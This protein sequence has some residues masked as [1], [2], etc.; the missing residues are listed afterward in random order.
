MLVLMTLPMEMIRNIFDQLVPDMIV[1]GTKLPLSD[2]HRIRQGAL[3]NLTLV[4]HFIGGIATEFLYRNLVIESTEQMVCLFRTL[5]DKPELRRHTWF[6]AN[7]V[8]LM[9]STIQEKIE[10]DIER[11]FPTFPAT[12][13]G[14]SYIYPQELFHLDAKL[15]LSCNPLWTHEI[16]RYILAMLPRLKDTLITIRG[17]RHFLPNTVGPG[18]TDKGFFAEPPNI[19]LPSGRPR[20]LRIQWDSN[21]LASRDQSIWGLTLFQLYF[22]PYISD[23]CRVTDL[24]FLNQ[25][26][27][28]SYEIQET[29]YYCLDQGPGRD[30]LAIKSEKNKGLLR[31]LAQLETLSLGSSDLHPVKVSQLLGACSSLKKLTWD[32]CLSLPPDSSGVASAL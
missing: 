1:T 25:A 19:P 27:V 23:G 21:T 13:A 5:C 2:E 4:S 17:G 11:H 32:P 12:V 15:L 28:T 22:N 9:D 29:S 10:A 16:I 24:R 8:T 31:W 30:C 20:T 26:N 3:R 14:P 18:I 6:V 7:L